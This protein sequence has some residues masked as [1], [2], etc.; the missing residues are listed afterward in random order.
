MAIL[1]AISTVRAVIVFTVLSGLLFHD[2][3]LAQPDAAAHRPVTYA[4][5]AAM[6]HSFSFVVEKRAA[7]SHLAPY[8]RKNI[9]MPEDGLNRLVLQNLDEYIGASAPDSKR[10]FLSVPTPAVNL[11][12]P[13]K[14]EQA[15]IDAV[16]KALQ[17][18]PERAA[19]D[20]IVVVTP[21]YRL[22][23]KNEMA[24][25]LG[26]FGIFIQPMCRSTLHELK[27]DTPA[28]LPGG[29][30]TV[31]TP[32]GEKIAS[33]TF[34]APFSYLS[35]WILD[36]KTLAVI[37][38]EQVFDDQKLNDLTANP[39]SPVQ[40]MDKQFTAKVVN[41]L[42]NSSIHSAIRRSGLT[43]KVVVREVKE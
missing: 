16:V 27:C 4:L 40:S 30:A 43:A 8:D 41:N 37:S 21:A 32:T 5:V 24:S 6:G 15:A 12:A 28:D 9:D 2:K 19:W 25:M 36:P 42:I 13:A 39:L 17:A 11:L 35:I 18:Y 14:R 33:T 29:P 1:P 26:G 20:K 34:Q 31:L 38:H 7:G 3:A 22:Q 23:R 10:I